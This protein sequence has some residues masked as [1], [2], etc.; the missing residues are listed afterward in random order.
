MDFCHLVLVLEQRRH[1]TQCLLDGAEHS[2][3]LANHRNQSIA[4][5]WQRYLALPI[6][7][8]LEKRVRVS[9][10]LDRSNVNNPFCCSHNGDS[11]DQSSWL[12]LRAAR[13]LGGEIAERS[14]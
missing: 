9:Q 4:K 12:G 11:L 3:S 10:A 2:V 1:T 6:G 8:V 13:D 7:D 14:A 5:H